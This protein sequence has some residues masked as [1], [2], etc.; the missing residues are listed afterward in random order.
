MLAGKMIHYVDHLKNGI[1][2][3]NPDVFSEI[4]FVAAEI[5]LHPVTRGYYQ[6]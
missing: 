6:E 1:V 5:K 4:D 2:S 3:F